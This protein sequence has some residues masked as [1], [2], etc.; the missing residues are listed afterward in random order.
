MQSML[1]PAGT[2]AGLIA[3]L[4]WF[5]FAVSTVVFLVVLG[6]TAYALS[7]RSVPTAAAEG[8]KLKYVAGGTAATVVI[9]ITI[10]VASVAA[11]RSTV[12][13]PADALT[14]EV[15]GHQWWWE[16]RYL[17]PSP[18]R[19]VTTANE[20]HLPAGERVRFVLR[21]A[22]VVHSFWIPSLAG[23]I[24]MFP[25]R[26][27][28][29]WVEATETGVFRGQC[30]E[31]CGMQHA[32]M[33]LVAVV[34][35]PAEFRAWLERE[36]APAA[37]PADELALRGR[38]VFMGGTCATCHRI[39]GTDAH[40]TFGPE[41]THI[42]RRR[43]LAAGTMPNDRGRMAAWLVDPQQIKPGS[44]MPPTNLDP[45]SLHALVHYLEQ[46]R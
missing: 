4:W 23:K 10:L 2:D 6:F 26:E 46:L 3:S 35:E 39:R 19:M 33:A 30:A 31:F 42:G 28:R 21:S 43:T 17:D 20:V 25:D 5:F 16:V 9:L 27:N 29:L 41:L 8:T 7:T 36:R 45:E 40:A 44:L 32:K 12:T 1:A 13:G 34:H 38:E 14:I 15:I 24:D 18:H 22:D 11:G 37:E